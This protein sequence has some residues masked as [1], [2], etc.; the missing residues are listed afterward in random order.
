MVEYETDIGDNGETCIMYLY[1]I[2]D[3]VDEFIIRGDSDEKSIMYN[4]IYMIW[5]IHIF[6]PFLPLLSTKVISVF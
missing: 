6:L 3:G 5:I 2:V 4:T 1:E